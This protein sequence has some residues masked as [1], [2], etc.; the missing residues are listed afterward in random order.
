MP[1]MKRLLGLCLGAS[2]IALSLAA[3]DAADSGMYGDPRYSDPCLQYASCGTCTP[4]PGCGWCFTAT[5]GACVSHPDECAGATSFGWTW[6]QSGCHVPA[7]AGTRDGV[8][9]G[10]IRDAAVADAP[11]DVSPSD[12][13]VAPLDAR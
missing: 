8:D 7:D 5:S 11:A 3:C 12:A 13:A 9:G 10:S 1:V 2:T 4:V 6:E